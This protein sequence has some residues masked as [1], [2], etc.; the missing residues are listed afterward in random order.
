MFFWS[1]HRRTTADTVLMYLMSRIDD[2]TV[3]LWPRGALNQSSALPPNGSSVRHHV[4]ATASLHHC[5]PQGLCEGR[6]WGPVHSCMPSIPYCRVPRVDVGPG[7]IGSVKLRQLGSWG[8]HTLRRSSAATSFKVSPPVDLLG[9]VGTI[10]IA[11]SPRANWR[12]S[13]LAGG[14]NLTGPGLE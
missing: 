1:L 13:T 4:V 8:H 11:S 6:I 9:W 10:A 14:R 3:N 5:L 12:C 2:G 7:N